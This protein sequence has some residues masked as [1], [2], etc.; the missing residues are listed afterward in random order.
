[1][2]RS[3]D[4]RRHPLLVALLGAVGAVVALEV[5]GAAAACAILAL[6]VVTLARLGRWRTPRPV[7][8]VCVRVPAGFPYDHAFDDLFARCAAEANLVGI[9]APGSCIDLE[10]DVRLRRGRSSGQLLDGLRG[11]IDGPNPESSGR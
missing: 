9:H 11:C 7:E 5:A 1:M 6:V 4:W 2:K 8:R 10:Y 3:L